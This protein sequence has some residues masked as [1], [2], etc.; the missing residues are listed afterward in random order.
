MC[1]SSGLLVTIAVY[2]DDG[3]YRDDMDYCHSLAKIMII[4]I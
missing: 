4:S 2:A 1:V 3:E